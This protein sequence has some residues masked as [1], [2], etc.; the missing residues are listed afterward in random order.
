MATSVDLAL[1]R[2]CRVTPDTRR[3]DKVSGRSKGPKREFA[4]I[5]CA[6][7]RVV[8]RSWSGKVRPSFVLSWCITG[9]L[10]ASRQIAFRQL[11]L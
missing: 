9:H 7:G 1:S 11:P 3:R 4:S 2:A 10:I 5:R 6:S 8:N